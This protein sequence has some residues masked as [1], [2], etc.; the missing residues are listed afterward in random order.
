MLDA[1]SKG[2][3]VGERIVYHRKRRKL[4]QQQLADLAG[5]SVCTI[6]SGAMSIKWTLQ[7][8]NF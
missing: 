3:T 1:L 7:T 8:E 6:K 4:S 5:L 2:E